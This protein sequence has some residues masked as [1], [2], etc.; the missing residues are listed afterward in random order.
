M[1]ELVKKIEDKGLKKTWLARQLGISSTLLS[2]YLTGTRDM[3]EDR[4]RKLEEILS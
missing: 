1:V 3:P 2:F 4:K